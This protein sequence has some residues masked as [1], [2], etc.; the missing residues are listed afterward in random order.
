MRYN[1]QDWQMKK[2]LMMKTVCKLPCFICYVRRV[3]HGFHRIPP[4]FAL[5]LGL[6]Y[7]KD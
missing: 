5:P 7:G 3:G 6:A 2:A 4:Y 1:N